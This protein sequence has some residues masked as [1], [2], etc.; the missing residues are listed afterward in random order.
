MV[1][2]SLDLRPKFACA[3]RG[4][5][6]KTRLDDS[7]TQDTFVA[8]ILRALVALVDVNRRLPRGGVSR[9]RRGGSSSVTLGGHAG[10]F[11]RF[12]GPI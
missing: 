11:E 2:W 8:C 7:I 5:V 12:E 6:A 3:L 10:T 1:S 4:S 9:P